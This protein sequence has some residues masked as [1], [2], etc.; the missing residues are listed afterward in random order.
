VSKGFGGPNLNIL[1]FR[2]RRSAD[3]TVPFIT[4]LGTR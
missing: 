4:F 3:A 1:G 2:R